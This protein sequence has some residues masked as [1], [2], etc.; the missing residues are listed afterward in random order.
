MS[1]KKD[2]PWKLCSHNKHKE[3]LLKDAWVKYIS[4][5]QAKSVRHIN[6][7]LVTLSPHDIRLKKK[8]M[9][10]AHLFTSRLY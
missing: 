9:D 3:Q 6:K 2:C 1:L 5:S 10:L 8:L 4:D 7:K